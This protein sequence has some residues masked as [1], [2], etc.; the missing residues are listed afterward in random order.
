MLVPLSHRAINLGSIRIARASASPAG[1]RTDHKLISRTKYW[2]LRRT[3][4][5]QSFNETYQHRFVAVKQQVHSAE[6][7]FRCF[8]HE[9]CDSV[10]RTVGITIQ[11]AGDSKIN[12]IR[13]HS[14]REMV[15]LV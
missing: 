8:F 3:G 4:V 10:G 14:R 15:S 1:R 11:P 13:H 2:S 6:P 7:E 5:A 9:A 12:Q